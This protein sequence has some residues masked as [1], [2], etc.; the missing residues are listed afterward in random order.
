MNFTKS[1]LAK[2]TKH[3]SDIAIKRRGKNVSTARAESIKEPNVATLSR[4]L[5]LWSSPGAA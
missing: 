3:M 4:G 1:T 2:A 5:N